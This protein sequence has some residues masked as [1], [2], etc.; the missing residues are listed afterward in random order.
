MNNPDNAI[1]YARAHHGEHLDELREFVSIP[2]ISATPAHAADIR[3]A[4]EWLH[5]WIGTEGGL[6]ELIE[7]DGPPIVWGEFA[8]KD[9][10][11][12]SILVYGH[13]DVQP[14]DPID[15]WE[16]DPFV[17]T[18]RG[19]R[20]FG[21]GASDMKA[22]IMAALFAVR[23]I[24]KSDGLPV[25][26]RVLLEGEEE[27]GSPNLAAALKEH[28]DRFKADVCVNADTGMPDAELPSICYGLRGLAYFELHLTGPARDLHSG[29][30]GGVVHNPAQALAEIISGLHDADGR[31]TL[32]GFYDRVRE[33][34]P[35]ERDRL[36]RV[37]LGDAE[38]RKLSGVP[39]LWGESAFSPAERVSARPTLEING[40]ESGYTGPGAKTVIPAKAMA[41]ISTRLV[42]DQRPEEI[43]GQLDAYLKQHV[44]PTISYN[45]VQLAQSPSFICDPTSP[46]HTALSSAL[47]AVWGVEPILSRSGGSVPVASDLQELLGVP[48]VLTGFGL[49]DDQ[50]HSPNESL[51]LPT[52]HRGT[53]A[54][55]R[56]M[57]TYGASSVTE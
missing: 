11:A 48:S 5:D 32:P 4:A 47:S 1:D 27:I 36:A 15:L 50:I 43:R 29:A 24:L 6:A 25:T 14:V 2:S 37:P 39:Q 51:H 53:E 10:D 19:D 52:W 12:P 21:R 30:F 18:L 55:I 34:D 38:I 54:L 3:R 22:Q 20:L 26:V 40:L 9:P 16:S 41:K 23:S 42:P 8:A 31:V 33:I 28:G 49:P 35:A 45:L 13:Y 44:Q 17:P 7:T 56:F 46:A 57:Y